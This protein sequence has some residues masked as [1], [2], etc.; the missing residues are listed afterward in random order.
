[1]MSLIWWVSSSG[2]R[3]MQTSVFV[4]VGEIAD[5]QRK[6]FRVQSS[7]MKQFFAQIFSLA[8]P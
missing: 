7:M 4:N 8:L 1:M 6:N 3:N 5:F 2:V